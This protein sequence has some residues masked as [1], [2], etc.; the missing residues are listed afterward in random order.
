MKAHELRPRADSGNDVP[1]RILI[2]THRRG[3]LCVPVCPR[4]GVCAAGGLWYMRPACRRASGTAGE[5]R[6]ALRTACHIRTRP[7][8]TT[9]HIST[10]T[11]ARPCHICTGTEARPCHICTGTGLTAA[12]SA[13][14]LG[15]PPGTSAPGLTGRV[16][17]SNPLY[18]MCDRCRVAWPIDAADRLE[19]Q[20][21]RSLR[22]NGPAC[23]VVHSY[24]RGPGADVGQSW[25]RCGSSF[26]R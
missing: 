22:I 12:S 7:R 6:A 24:C 25:G 4:V 19:Q 13:P 16:G 1:R 17:L 21:Q 15:S 10:R 2:Q 11:G 26:V 3:A 8:L 9:C 20:R 14:G 5:G 23:M 18:D